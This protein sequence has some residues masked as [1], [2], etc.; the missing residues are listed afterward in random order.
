MNV[1]YAFSAVVGQGVGLVCVRIFL[2]WR[3]SAL[4]YYYQAL[5]PANA[6]FAGIGVL[7][8]VGIFHVL[9]ANYFDS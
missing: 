1:L 2:S 8:V 9:P 6:I 4:T 7:F 5:P 3:I